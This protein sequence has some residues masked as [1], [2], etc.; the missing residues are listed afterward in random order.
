MLLYALTIACSAFLLFEVQPIV[1][2][3]ILPWFGGSSAVWSTCL[4]FFQLALLLGYLYAHWLHE[5]LRG[6]LQ[7]I[8]HIGALALSCA[9]LPILPNPWWKTA[10][11][12]PSLKILALLAVT[13]GLPYFLLAST[14]PLLQ[15]WY[16][17]THKSG[18]PYR[19]FALSNFASL[20][21]LLS[22]PFL[23][24][25]NLPT[26]MQAYVWSGGY[27]CFAVL[28]AIAAWRACNHPAGAL[29]PMESPAGAGQDVAAPGPWNRL[30]WF[31]LS[32]AASVLLLAVTNHLTQD[33]AAIPL[34]WIVPLSA[35]LLSFI[36]CFE[37]PRLYHRAV[38][39]PL[40]VAALGF[41]TYQ[42]W[43]D[44]RSMKTSLAIELLAASLFICCMACHGELARLKPLPRGLTW[45]YVAVS[46]GGAMGGL[47]VGLVAPNFFSAYYEF[48]LG[49]GLAAAVLAAVYARGLW[50]FPPG[51]RYA[52]AALI[53]LIMGGYG[54]C[55]FHIM[56]QMT[57]GYRLV[58]RNFYGQLRVYDQGN[59]IF[60]DAASRALVHGTVNHGEQFLR[61][62]YRRRPV[63]Y[64]C[65]ESGVGRAMGA[66][67]GSG[68]SLGVI[69]LGCGTLAAYGKP[70]DTLR[71]YEINPLVLEI[72]TT[73]FTYL[74]DTPAKVQVAM[75]DARLSLE[76][77][78]GRRFDILVVDA[79]SG[80]AVPVHLLTLEAFREYF[81][82]L[83][84]DGI[85]AVNITNRYL[86]LMPVMERAASAFG[87]VALYFDYEA[88]PN[89]AFCFSC[90]WMLIMDPDTLAAHAELKYGG[91]IM[92]P[93]PAFRA[94]TD[95]FS[96]LYSILR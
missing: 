63:T 39:L 70:G 22:Y 77:E 8:V 34:L 15:A 75:G 21:A 10:G 9:A 6:R 61:E 96:N 55:L 1:A 65:P 66:L 7:A 81:R 85:L 54:W 18:L 73:Q 83:K 25:P 50:H 80:D 91:R 44:H 2:K 36:L 30:L 53:V 93:Q 24:E 12:A 5:K 87:K 58:T 78:P 94:W 32:A 49:L 37:A 95:D 84:P 60:E 11:G 92:K 27:I 13:V 64:F 16:A 41:M 57:V 26:R 19:L 20:L 40:T 4:L 52:G 42:M 35:Y 46:L 90:D 33:I 86:D 79:F 59:P 88:D 38:F 56:R 3:M 14:S 51:P 47:F 71:I 82:R 48:P 74:R 45:F 43:P 89:D 69:G 17:R 23:V 31:G 68:R 28:C 62:A 29:P 72:A 67:A 76:S